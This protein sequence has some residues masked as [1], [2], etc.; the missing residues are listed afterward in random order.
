MEMKRTL[1]PK[2]SSP[3]LLCSL[4]QRGQIE[5]KAHLPANNSETP[6]LNPEVGIVLGV[7]GI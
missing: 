5:A 1:S 2:C 3:F 4:Q 6:G 7:L